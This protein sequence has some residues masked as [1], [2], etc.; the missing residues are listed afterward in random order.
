LEKAGERRP[1]REGQREKVSWRRLRREGLLTKAG[2]R[3]PPGEGWREK[4]RQ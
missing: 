2:R 3:R 1:P 4:V